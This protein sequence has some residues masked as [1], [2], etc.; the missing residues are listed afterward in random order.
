MTLNN[1]TNF[2]NKLPSQTRIQMGLVHLFLALFVEISYLT[3]KFTFDLEFT[4]MP[5]TFKLALIGFE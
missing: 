1:Q 3:L 5:E 2:R 4:K